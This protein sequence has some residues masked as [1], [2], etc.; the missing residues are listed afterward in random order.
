MPLGPATNWPKTRFPREE[1][2][3]RPGLSAIQGTGPLRSLSRDNGNSTDQDKKTHAKAAACRNSPRTR[4]WLRL[5]CWDLLISLND[6]TRFVARTDN[7]ANFTGDA[8]SM[9]E[10]LPSPPILLSRRE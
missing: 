1:G 9:L 4:A 2:E 7:H 3:A 6:L 5:V 8:I 10:A